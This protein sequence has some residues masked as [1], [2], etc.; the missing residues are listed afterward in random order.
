VAIVVAPVGS[1]VVDTVIHKTLGFRL[2]PEEER[3]G[4]DLAI[5]R[6]GAE[7]ERDTGV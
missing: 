2:S 3:R 1:F 5:H 4:A 7:P 6:V